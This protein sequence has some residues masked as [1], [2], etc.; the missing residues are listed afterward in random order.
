MITAIAS[1]FK[2]ASSS[3]RANQMR[4]DVVADNIANSYTTGFRASRTVFGEAL[5]SAAQP[6]D[7]VEVGRYQGVRV[8][9]ISPDVAQGILSPSES[10]WHLAIEGLGFFQIRT[11]G[12]SL[13]Y[14]RDGRFATSSERELVTANG[15]RLEPPVTLPADAT[16]FAVNADGI[17][18]GQFESFDQATG[19]TIIQVR[20]VG[21]ISLAGFINP[22]GLERLGQNLYGSTESSGSALQRRPD[23]HRW[24][25]I[26][27]NALEGS[28]AELVEAMM[29][30]VMAQRAYQ[31]SARVLRTVDDMAGMANELVR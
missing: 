12:G 13:A 31:L 29:E 5:N 9:E 3:L 30:M 18:L 19:Q 25:D 1:L 28:N 8:L 15:Y 7:G 20:E 21:R 17:I 23:G 14:T 4:L 24:G 27:G 22:E 16:A 6:E 10:C 11:P 26:V 2:L